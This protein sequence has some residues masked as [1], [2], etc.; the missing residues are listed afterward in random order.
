VL[1]HY[2]SSHHP[3]EGLRPG[4]THPG[5]DGQQWAYTKDTSDG[6]AATFTPHKPLRGASTE[7]PT[8]GAES[9]WRYS[10]T[11]YVCRF[12]NKRIRPLTWVDGKWRWRAPESNRPMLLSHP[13]AAKPD[14]TV[15][16]VEGEKTWDTAQKLFPDLI[17]CCWSGGCKAIAKTNF[18]P[19]AGRKVALWPDNDDAGRD[20]MDR[21]AQVLY[22]VGAASVKVVAN[23]DDAPQ[24]WDLADANWTTSEA[25][26]WVKVN[27]SAVAKRTV[28]GVPRK[29]GE[30]SGTATAAG[31][32]DY[33]RPIRLETH[34]V[35][36]LLQ[37]RIGQL[38]LNVRS[39]EVIA[40]HDKGPI[41]LCW[42]GSHRLI[43]LPTT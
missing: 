33:S 43:L 9:V 23:P 38:R 14:A 12:Q 36:E 6:R 35:M 42:R 25:A 4:D 1:C 41:T 11:F 24:G 10:A 27:T 31:A 18:T 7:P 39:G 5:G 3:P 29:S 32:G 17:A 21:L 19:L 16:I 30:D 2:G 26:A 8:R 20:A 13:L 22:G 37:K 15:L 28:T 34:Q 40:E